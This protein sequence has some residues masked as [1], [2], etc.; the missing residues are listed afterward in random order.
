MIIKINAS[1]QYEVVTA[2]KING[3]IIAIRADGTEIAIGGDLK[4]IEVIDG[5]I[6]EEPDAVSTDYIPRDG[7]NIRNN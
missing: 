6:I 4:N 1:T 2:E 5:E 3:Q 7:T